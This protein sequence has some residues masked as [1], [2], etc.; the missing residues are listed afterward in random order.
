MPHILVVDDM[1]VFREPLAM[2]LQAKGYTTQCAEN[3]KEALRVLN[4]SGADLVLLDVAMPV[5]DGLEFL[6]TIRKNPQYKRLPVILLTAVAERDYVIRA[7]KLGVR[8]YLLKGSF[9]LPTLHERVQQQLNE[10]PPSKPVSNASPQSPTERQQPSIAPDTPKSPSPT[11]ESDAQVDL[12]QDATGDEAI[13]HLKPRIQRSQLEDQLEIAGELKALSPTVADILKMTNT[14]DCSIE[15][16]AKA[17]RRDHAISLKVL[18]MAN[19]AVYTRG[20]PVESIDKAV[21]R[22]GLSQ[23]RQVAMNISVIDSFSSAHTAVDDWLNPMLFWEHCIAT[24]LIAAHTTK[25]L[26][27]DDTEVDTAFTAGL[28]HDVGKMVFVEAFTDVYAQALQT[29]ARL[30][31]PL[32]RVEKRLLLANHAD[33]MDKLLHRWKFAKHLVDPIALHHL[34]VANIRGIARSSMQEVCVLA[35]ANRLAHAL[36]LGSGGNDTIYPT[37]EFAH[38]LKLDGEAIDTILKDI[39]SQTTDLKLVLL[40]KGTTRNWVNRRKHWRSKIDA[41]FRPVFVGQ[42]A[43]LDGYRLFVNAIGDNTTD[44][45]PNLI[46]AV[47]GSVKEQQKVTDDVRRVEAQHNMNSLPVIVISPKGTL[48]LKDAQTNSRT[49]VQLTM[50]TPVQ[51]FC[52]AADRLLVS[53]PADEQISNAA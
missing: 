17:I 6:K 5:M 22:I 8:D 50:P 21:M 44:E 36:L 45:P 39:D 12:P 34:S 51:T 10:K 1:A 9:S 11:S 20:E 15:R 29:S 4:T 19:S 28:L 42:E 26:N 2:A 43:E 3:G 41:Q 16:I 35:L 7:A 27:G 31:L 25:A 46:V 52:D 32:E 24:G 38:A 30:E 48:N 40:E 18:K 47:I 53:S 33:I 23:I 14:R 13:K 49:T 37:R